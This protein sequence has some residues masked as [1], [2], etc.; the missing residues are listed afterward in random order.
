MKKDELNQDIG[1][2]LVS[3]RKEKKIKAKDIAEALGISV[4]AW[5]FVESGKT[6]LTFSRIW[7]LADILGVEMYEVIGYTPESLCARKTQELR[8]QLKAYQDRIIEVQDE[9]NTLQE[10]KNVLNQKLLLQER[11]SKLKPHGLK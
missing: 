9:K 8:D 6:E 5:G 1:R 7:Q 3:L 2:H 11:K 4:T 10:E